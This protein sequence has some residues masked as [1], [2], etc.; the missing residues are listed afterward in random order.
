MY[1]NVQTIDGFFNEA[2][3]DFNRLAIGFEPTIRRLLVNQ[4]K[5]NTGGYPPFNLEQIDDNH[6]RITLAVAGFAMEE[7]DVVVADNQLTI[8]GVQKND[9]SRNYLHKGIAE[10]D[11]TRNFVLAD[12]VNVISARLDN[13]LLVIDLVQEIPDVLKP[14]KIAITNG[15]TVDGNAIESKIDLA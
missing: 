9:Q 4:N 13:G 3:R 7:L 5:S 11:F 14:K 8:S 2:M 10:R 15:A 12:H 6:Y 1:H